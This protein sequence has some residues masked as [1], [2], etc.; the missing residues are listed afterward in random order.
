MNAKIDLRPQHLK[1]V[2]QLLAEQLHGDIKV[3]VFGSRATGKAKKYSDLDLALAANDRTRLAADLV[4]DL[5]YAFEESKLPYKVDVVDMAAVA[6]NFKRIIEPT[7]VPLV[8]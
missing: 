8:V 7:R 6:K 1:I 3:W 2:Q 5:K 4:L